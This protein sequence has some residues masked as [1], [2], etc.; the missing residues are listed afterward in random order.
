[1]KT[2]TFITI[3]QALAAIIFTLLIGE[4]LLNYLTPEFDLPQFEWYEISFTLLVCIAIYVLLYIIEK[5]QKDI[6]KLYILNANRSTVLNS[7]SA[8]EKA[9]LKAAEEGDKAIEYNKRLIR[10]MKKQEE[11]TD[12]LNA[13]MKTQKRVTNRLNKILTRVTQASN[14]SLND[15]SEGK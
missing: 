11:T 3:C 8:I 2:T 14:I 9:V 5:Q 12:R 1:M 15:V 4:V 6:F 7:V 10:I 13:V